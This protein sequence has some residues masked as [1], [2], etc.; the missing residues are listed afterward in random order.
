MTVCISANDNNSDNNDSY[1]LDL[2][3]VAPAVICYCRI[4]L[5]QYFSMTSSLLPFED[6]TWELADDATSREFR[7]NK[8]NFNAVG[9]SRKKSLLTELFF[10][11]T[12]VSVLVQLS[13]LTVWMRDRNF[14]WSLSR[15]IQKAANHNMRQI[16]VVNP[17]PASLT[18]ATHSALLC[19]FLPPSVDSFHCA[20]I[21]ALQLRIWKRG[22]GQNDLRR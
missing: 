6:T 3:S 19:I 2:W 1:N 15:D 9:S 5:L 10:I 21:K 14:D 18:V 12:K 17:D 4:D 8:S 20:A 11:V 16:Q 13:P 22:K 7:R